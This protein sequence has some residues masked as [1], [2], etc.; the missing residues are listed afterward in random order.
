[1]GGRTV[2]WLSTLSGLF[3]VYMAVGAVL[4]AGPMGIALWPW[5]FLVWVLFFRIIVFLGEEMGVTYGTRDDG[6][7]TGEREVPSSGPKDRRISPQEPDRS[8]LRATSRIIGQVAQ[9]GHVHTKETRERDSYQGDPEGDRATR[10]FA[11]FLR[12]S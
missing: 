3:A 4:R 5:I 1:M 11:D 12:S 9:R 6:G 8:S 10:D 2:L 7:D